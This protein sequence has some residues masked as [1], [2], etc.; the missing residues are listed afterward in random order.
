LLFLAQISVDGDTSTN[1]TVIGL[2]SGAG[3]NPLISDH[4]SAEAKQLEEAVTA[5]LQVIYTA[6]CS[7]ISHGWQI[8][9]LNQI[10]FETGAQGLAKSVAWDGEGAT[11]LIEVQ[12]SGASSDE[13]ARKIAK[14]V[15]ASSLVK[16]AIYGHDPNWGRIACAAG[17]AASGIHKSWDT[18]NSVL[19][20]KH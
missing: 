18:S 20:Q 7:I 4:N 2:A 8:L 1:D 13:G 16:A 14:S 12:A 17:Y 11:C 9:G 10:A 5:L 3:G 19:L 6:G 15:V